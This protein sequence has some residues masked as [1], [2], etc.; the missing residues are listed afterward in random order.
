MCPAAETTREHVP[1][2]AF[3]PKSMRQN[4]WTVPSC[5]L[6]NVDHSA[7]VEYVRNAVCIQDGT[8]AV[9]EQ[10]LEVAKRSWEYSPGLFKRT[11][12]KFRTMHIG[13]EEK[14]AFPFD[15]PRVERVMSAIAH[16]LAY[17]DFGRA[18]IGK[19]RV[20][21]AT[22][23]SEGPSPQWDAFREMVRNA[24]YEPVAVPVPHVFAYAIHRMDTG[25]IYRM[26]FYEGFVVHTWPVLTE[27]E[28]G[29]GGAQP[30]TG[31][32]QPS[33]RTAGSDAEAGC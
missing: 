2:R 1:P 8:N 19:W 26:T 20:F 3:F 21:C 32:P 18:Y 10:T 7:D 28:R 25:F 5:E 27:G 23:R 16:G 15:L 31:L 30:T 6:H 33:P 24:G 29:A 12:Q 4:L 22:L 13:G 9:A 17:R 11:F 14:G